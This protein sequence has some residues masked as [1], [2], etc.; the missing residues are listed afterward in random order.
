MTDE[1]E[2]RKPIKITRREARREALVTA[3]ALLDHHRF[4][5]FDDTRLDEHDDREAYDRI[6]AER[7]AIVKLLC[8]WA[9]WDP[10]N[11]GWEK[12]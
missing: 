5:S 8:K 2:S 10:E 4:D 1:D 3:A 6:N 11:L 12:R 9:N 7:H